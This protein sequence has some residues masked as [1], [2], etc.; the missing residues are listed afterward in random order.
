MPIQINCPDCQRPLRVPD[1]LVGTQVRC[2][3]C[4]RIFRAS[5]GEENP[6]ALEASFREETP[7]S[8]PRSD[9]GS[10]RRLPPKPVLDDFEEEYDDEINYRRSRRRYLAPHRGGMILTFGILGII[11]PW[12]CGPLWFFSILAW[13]MGHGDLKEIKA[14]RMDP[15]GE[16]MTKAGWIMGIIGTVLMVLGIAA[17]MLM[18]IA[19]AFK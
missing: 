19:G 10:M 17:C 16:G 18:F 1:H 4:Q 15:D 13:I 7:R 3:G 11:G 12:L 2:P 14:G 8:A 5:T 9:E 6:P